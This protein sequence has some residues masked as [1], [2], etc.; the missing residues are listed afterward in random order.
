MSDLKFISADIE[1]DALLDDITRTWCASFR[2]HE[3][4]GGPIVQQYTTTKP[5]EMIAEFMN[6]NNVLVMHNGVGYDAP[7][8]EKV[9]GIKVQAEIIDT[10]FLSWYLEPKRLKHG[11]AGYG[12]EFGVPKPEIDDWENLTINQYCHR[13]EEDTKIQQILW[14]RQ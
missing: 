1:A 3:G 2:T 11:L 6:P 7:A 4:I 9:Y 5:D 10:L 8:M 12:E 14:R 13:V